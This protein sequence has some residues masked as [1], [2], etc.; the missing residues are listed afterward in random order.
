MDLD[1]K[2]LRLLVAVCDL[3]NMKQAAEQEHIEPSAIS[4]RIAQL[5]GRLGVQ[6]LVRGRRGVHPTPA[7]EAVLEHARSVLF[8]L[9]RLHSDAAAFAGGI[10]G[11]VKVAASVSAIAESLLDD[12]AAFMDEPSNRHISV[13]VEERLSRELVQLVRDGAASLGVCWDAGD[14]RRLQTRLYRRDE[15]VLAVHVSHPLATLTHVRFEDSLGY[16]HVGLP[17]ATAVHTMLNRAAA[18]V[19]RSVTYRA[20]VSNF[21]AALRVVV[22]Y[23]CVSILP[24]Q[25]ALRAERDGVFAVALSDAWAQRRF[26]ICFRNYDELTPAAAR[27]VDYLEARGKAAADTAESVSTRNPPRSTARWRRRR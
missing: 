16:E 9:E 17:P 8:T 18:Q 26:A 20:V 1:I 12:L 5:E 2:T 7:G 3:Q 21:D 15:L 13:S 14:F 27:L 23:R 10:K 19:G 11:Q 4:K 6:L 25:V 24:R 22:A